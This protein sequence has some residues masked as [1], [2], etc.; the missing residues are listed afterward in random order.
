LH[1]ENKIDQS[2]KSVS[3]ATSELTLSQT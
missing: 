1:F 3:I 2:W